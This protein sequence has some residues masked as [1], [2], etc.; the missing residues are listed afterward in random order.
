M[1]PDLR[2]SLVLDRSHWLS[3]HIYG[4]R[5]ICSGQ[6]PHSP[7]NTSLDV[8]QV[9]MHLVREMTGR[10]RI[11]QGNENNLESKKIHVY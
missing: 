10:G 1:V 4:K 9:S 6:Y 3:T 7:R 8:Y 11:S 2:P 5:V